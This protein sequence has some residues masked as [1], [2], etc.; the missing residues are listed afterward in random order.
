M[1]NTKTQVQN[2]SQ[3]GN[4][5]RK[6]IEGI[7]V[8]IDKV[9]SEIRNKWNDDKKNIW[10]R[11]SAKASV[12]FGIITIVFVVVNAYQTYLNVSH[13]SETQRAFLV[14]NKVQFV[15]YGKKRKDIN[16]WV[17]SAII[18]NGGN[19]PTR[20]L[21]ISF[22]TGMGGPPFSMINGFPWR[23]VPEV[24]GGVIGPKG[25]R[26]GPG[27]ITSANDLANMATGHYRVSMAGVITYKDIFGSS[28]RSEFCFD[29]IAPPVDF[30]N[31]PI[32]QI[33]RQTPMF[34]T[35]HNCTDQECLANS[36]R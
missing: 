14:S 3:H 26:L 5:N 1:H 34:C 32:G 31:Y 13:F 4:Q 16:E 17:L 36:E 24:S 9:T 23:D 29:V 10:P 33:I 30:E 2:P 22:A 7:I 27:Y 11:R 18:E 8:S 6:S 19:T 20:D 28:H 12:F 21:K 25:E 35:E 15:T